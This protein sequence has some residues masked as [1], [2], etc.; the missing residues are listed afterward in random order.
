MDQS[1]YKYTLITNNGFFGNKFSQEAGVVSITGVESGQM[2]QY[3]FDLTIGVSITV[4]VVLFMFISFSKF[5]DLLG[6]KIETP[7]Y[8]KVK[9]DKEGLQNV[10]VGLVI[11]LSSWLILNTINPDFLKLSLFQGAMTDTSS[12]TTTVGSDTTTI[13]PATSE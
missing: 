11:L 2:F 13:E 7:S 1:N 3:L 10:I 8:I 9:K 4:A 12:E 6:Y 5:L